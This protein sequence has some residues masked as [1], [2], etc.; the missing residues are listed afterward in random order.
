[1]ENQGEGGKVQ[2]GEGGYK[3]GGG[4]RGTSFIISYFPSDSSIPFLSALLFFNSQA[5]ADG[6]FIC[7]YSLPDYLGG[8]GGWGGGYLQGN[9]LSWRKIT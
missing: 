1:M 7:V 8:G 9:V 2:R 3:G 6:V 4:V 5:S